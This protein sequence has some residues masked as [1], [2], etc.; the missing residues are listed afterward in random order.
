MLPSIVHISWLT[1]LLLGYS[2]YQEYGADGGKLNAQSFTFLLKNTLATPCVLQRRNTSPGRNFRKQAAVF[3]VA[4][5]CNRLVRSYYPCALDTIITTS[6]D[7]W[8]CKTRECLGTQ[9][10]KRRFLFRFYFFIY[11]LFVFV[12]FFVFIFVIF[13]LFDLTLNLFS[14]FPTKTLAYLV[15]EMYCKARL[16]QI[17]APATICVAGNSN[18][19]SKQ[20]WEWN[21]NPDFSKT[22]PS[23]R[24]GGGI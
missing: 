21:R 12:F 6:M 4:Y 9:L 24:G 10:P 16:F 13:F 3:K 15:M 19:V 11:F 7:S 17:W 23:Q 20:L 22:I 18:G 2:T 8:S 5:N 14:C 1:P